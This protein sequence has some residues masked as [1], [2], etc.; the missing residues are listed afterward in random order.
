M[1]P[2]L[3]PGPLRRVA[4]ADPQGVAPDP[5]RPE[6]LPDR[7]RAAAVAPVHLRHGVSLDLRQVPVGVVVE[8]PTP[9][10]DSLLASFRNSRYF[11]VR[12]V[13]HRSEVED[14]L[15]S[16]RLKGV[17]VLRGRLRRAARP[18]RDG[19]GPGHRRRQRPQHR[20]AGPGLRPGCLAELAGAGGGVEGRAGGPASRTA[21][22]HGRSRVTGSTRTSTAETS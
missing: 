20:R 8:Q 3:K 6:Q 17:I 13:R 5:P 11:A 12:E 7:R 2:A 1:M 16:G 21:A 4:G 19:P 22:D 15:V 10:A 18:R 14:D 9:E